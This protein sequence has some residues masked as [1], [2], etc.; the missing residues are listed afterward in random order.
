MRPRVPRSNAG[1][2][3]R[4]TVLHIYTVESL[5]AAVVDGYIDWHKAIVEA[6]V[7]A[8]LSEDKALH[9]HGHERCVSAL[10]ALLQFTHAY[11]Q[12]R[13]WSC[14]C[15]YCRFLGGLRN[16]LAH[17][18]TRGGDF[19]FLAARLR[20]G[21]VW[22][23]PHNATP[24][25][26]RVSCRSYV[27]QVDVGLVTRA[28]KKHRKFEEAARQLGEG[29]LRV[30]LVPAVDGY[31][32]CLSANCAA[33]R[34][35]HPLPEPDG[36]EHGYLRTGLLERAAALRRASSGSRPGTLGLVAAAWD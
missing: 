17:C 15:R 19:A 27:P 14:E 2:A 33:W 36:L 21:S 34:A 35:A 6:V 20:T 22:T 23:R 7:R 3:D 26:N 11:R 4:E 31:V 13:D 30:N 8:S 5:Y 28:L 12:G 25:A 9:L 18:W 24:D 1:D 16:Y 29:A 10:A 32:A